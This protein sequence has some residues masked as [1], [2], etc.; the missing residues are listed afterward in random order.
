M[1][2]AGLSHRDRAFLA[3]AL[4]ARYGGPESAIRDTVSRLIDDEILA[5]A[6]RTGLALRLAYTISGGVPRLLRRASLKLERG[7]LVLRLPGRGPLQGGEAVERRLAALVRALG[8]AAR[9]R[10]G[11]NRAGSKRR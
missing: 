9:I 11:P 2:A 3:V 7:S 10:V 5:D 1:A 4:H 8:V 6:R